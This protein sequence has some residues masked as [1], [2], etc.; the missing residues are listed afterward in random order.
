MLGRTLY[1]H[2]TGPMLRYQRDAFGEYLVIDELNPENRI[3][4]AMTPWEMLK[5]GLK[6][7]AAACLA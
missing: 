5:F 6:C 1:W 2:P 7:I 3:K 4:F